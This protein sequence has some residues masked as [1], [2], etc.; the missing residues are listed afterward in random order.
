MPLLL[1]LAVLARPVMYW[2]RVSLTRRARQGKHQ[3]WYVAGQVGDPWPTLPE[4]ISPLAQTMIA[5]ISGRAK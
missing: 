1:R 2:A 4:K 5:P 3:G